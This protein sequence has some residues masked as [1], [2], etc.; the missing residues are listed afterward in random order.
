MSL[1]QLELQAQKS[2]VAWGLLVPQHL[3]ATLELLVQAC[4]HPLHSCASHHLA[5][6]A[7]CQMR[8][9]CKVHTE[10]LYSADHANNTNL[11]HEVNLFRL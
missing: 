8:L 9:S 7:W 11:T 5:W 2:L 1:A 6:V 3:L 4:F 10:M